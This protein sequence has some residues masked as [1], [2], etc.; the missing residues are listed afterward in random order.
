MD[1]AKTNAANA[2]LNLVNYDRKNSSKLASTFYELE[3]Q[4]SPIKYVH[5]SSLSKRKFDIKI[6][7][8]HVSSHSK[9]L[10]NLA[11]FVHLLFLILMIV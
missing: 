1:E 7:W 2:Y 4:S 9:F 3:H 11:E 6:I 10:S 8:L 5:V